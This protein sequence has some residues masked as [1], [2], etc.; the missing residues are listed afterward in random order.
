VHLEEP[1]RIIYGRE[2]GPS[3]LGGELRVGDRP[4][5]RR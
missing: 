4:Q 2:V 5:P 3:N 1:D